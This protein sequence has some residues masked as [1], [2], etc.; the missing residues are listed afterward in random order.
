VDSFVERTEIEVLRV[1]ADW[2]GAGPAGAM[3]ELESKLPSLKGRRFYGAFRMLPDG[4]EYFACV[5]RIPSD[6]PGR[7]G[8]DVG[9]LPGGWY[10]RRKV[11]GWQ[12]VIRAG[13]LGEI[14]R[15]MVR[16]HGSDDTRPSLEYYRSMSEL[17]L[18]LPI[19][20]PA[21]T[22]RP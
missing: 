20:T 15:D 19:P 4:E 1:R 14:F 9:R 21:P 13:K 11:P 17:H 5:E 18:L 6:D 8:L 7:M 10:A 22:D 12:E 2:T 16:L 3:H